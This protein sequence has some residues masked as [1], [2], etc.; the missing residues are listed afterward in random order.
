MKLPIIKHLTA[1]IEENDEDF[2]VETI[3]TL[4]ALTEVPSLKDEELD[5]IG[6]LI[7]NMYGAIEVNKSIKEG[8]PKKDALNNFMKRVLG[9]IDG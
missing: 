8:V 1:F 6:E 3:E 5:V 7:S 4:E 2:V 9:S